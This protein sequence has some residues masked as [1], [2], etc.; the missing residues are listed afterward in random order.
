[1]RFLIPVLAFAAGLACFAG[2]GGEVPAFRPV[3]RPVLT[4][5]SADIPALQRAIRGGRGDLRPAL[6]EAYLQRARETADPAF[7][8]KA[9]AV[10]GRPRTAEALATAGELALARHDFRGAL[11]L[12]RRAGAVGAAIRVDALV[13]LGRYTDATRELQAMVDRKPNLAGYARVSYLRELRGHL[14]GAA[15]A[16]RLAVDAGGP[17]AENGAYVRAL[18]GE[19]ERRRGRRDAARRAFHRALALVPGHPGAT[20]GL[21]RLDAER[22]GGAGRAAG[23]GR[24]AATR[25]RPLV[26]R[27]PLP[28]YV[29]ALGEAE[30]AAGRS[31]ART[32]A[33]VGAEEQLL[34]AAGID[35]DVE[36][37]LFEA[38]HG[39]PR[40]A[41]ALARRG[42]AVA[43]STRAADALGWALTRAGRARD[44]YRYAR[45]ALRLGSVDPLWRAHAGLSAIAAG[46][47]GHHDL[48]V[49][50]AHGLDGYPWQ[51]RRVR[52]A[53]K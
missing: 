2:R 11:A 6:A 12:G 41:V 45:E 39:D 3:A 25:L 24:A 34:R 29:I 19:L 44:G 7:Y 52:S 33:L 8:A 46:K 26:Q 38:D 17:A 4:G 23:S 5:T 14:A 16:M 13:E 15:S 53:L 40:R 35:T 9:A 42:Y 27:L 37:A 21:A 31:A 36:L 49:A 28:E 43:P 48:R 51:A 32:F 1:M 30:L 50:L 20:A 10:L 47:D 18:L 22:A